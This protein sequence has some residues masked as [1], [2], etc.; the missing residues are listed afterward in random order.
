[1]FFN[2]DIWLWRLICVFVNFV[3]CLFCVCVVFL[4]ILILFCSIRIVCNVFSVLLIVFMVVLVCV[5]KGYWWCDCCVWLNWWLCGYWFVCVVWWFWFCG[6]VKLVFFFYLFYF[7][8]DNGLLFCGLYGLW[9]GCFLLYRC[10]VL[11]CGWGWLEMLC[12]WFVCY[13]FFVWYDN[14]MGG[15]SVR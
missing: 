4:S 14:V 7:W 5:I 10:W 13:D 2:C 15:V 3:R 9:N 11:F 12:V 1:M 8:W 6:W